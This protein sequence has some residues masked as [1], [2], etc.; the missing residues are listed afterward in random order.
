MI[1]EKVD[2]VLTPWAQLNNIQIIMMNRDWEIRS[3]SIKD[4]YKY[5]ITPPEK[6]DLLIKILD[7]KARKFLK[8][9]SIKMS[10]L[11]EYLKKLI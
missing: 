6:E 11:E 4:K 9:D 1:Y 10:G 7:H 2:E 5:L 8:A 3:F